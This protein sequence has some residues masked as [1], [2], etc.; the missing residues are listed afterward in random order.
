MTSTPKKTRRRSHAAT[1][2]DVGREA[3]VSEM[4]AS[5]VLNRPRTSARTSAETRERVLAAAERLRYRP[6]ATARALALQRMNTIGVVATRLGDE[7]DLYFLEVFSG[8]IQGATA[9]GQTTTVFTLNDWDEAELR[10]PAFCDGRI[11]GLLVLAPI[12]KTDAAAWLPA[13]TPLVSVHSNREMAW[14]VNLESDEEGGAFQ[15]VAR[16]LALGHRRI[17]HVGGPV[18]AAGADRRIAGYFR[19]HAEAGVSPP[20]DH[21]VRGEY[22]FE[23]GHRAMQE[24]LNRHRGEA[25]PDAV[26]GANDAIALACID[27]L[28][29]RGVR[30]PADVSVTGFDNTVL[31]R[32]VR[33]TSVR[34]PLR[35]L[36]QR[37]V[38]VLVESIEGRRR[39]VPYQGP[40]NIV[41]PTDIAVGSSLAEPRTSQLLVA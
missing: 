5:A 39:E 32:S 37:A 3:G 2:A 23:G 41:L 24:W 1:L 20:A 33:L 35:E 40:K 12:L 18:G 16:M 19:A 13:H 30:V 38:E 31:A 17:L 10:I 9:A 27:V 36:G 8:I 4:A 26:F 6:N 14:G 34:Q 29:S 21:V 22:S 25:L 28:Q 11:D 15:M 7:P